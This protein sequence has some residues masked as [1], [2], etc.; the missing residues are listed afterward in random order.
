MERNLSHSP[1]EVH[2]MTP[3]MTRSILAKY[4]H[5]DEGEINKGDVS[6]MVELLQDQME[7]WEE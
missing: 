5:K 4:F 1:K 6:E 3:E 2:A 7:N